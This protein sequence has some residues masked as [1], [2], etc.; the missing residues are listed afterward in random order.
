[1]SRID[2]DAIRQQ[3]VGQLPPDALAGM[4][5]ILPGVGLGATGLP[6]LP[7]RAYEALKIRSEQFNTQLDGEAR[8]F[9]LQVQQDKE[10]VF[11]QF[12][13]EFD[14]NG[15]PIMDGN[16][17]RLFPNQPPPPQQ[18]TAAAT[19]D[20]PTTT[21]TTQP[22]TT[23][24]P[25]TGQTVTTMETVTTVTNQ[26]M[27]VDVNVPLPAQPIPP[28][29]PE[30]RRQ[31]E[32]WEMRTQNQAVERHK[33]EKDALTLQQRIWFQD[34]LNAHVYDI[35]TPEVQQQI[36]AQAQAFDLQQ[37]QLKE[38]QQ[39]E[40]AQIGL[41]TQE[42]RNR[43]T[44]FGENRHRQKEEFQNSLRFTP[45]G[46]EIAQYE[47]AIKDFTA[48]QRAMVAQMMAGVT[49][50]VQL[51]RFL[52]ELQDPDLARALGALNFQV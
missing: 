16:T 31:R 27:T 6:P 30:Q 17:P 37:A 32:A 19:V 42:L 14:G 49:S 52:P 48:R 47:Q 29:S 41:P 50:Q 2:A 22:V 45:E 28:E 9:S 4:D 26:Q 46:Q 36:A 24:D 3:I 18:V 21:I 20:V 44:A 7:I 38:R 15:N 5:N 12:H 43:V 33:M 1:M 13:Y 34:F 25:V 11:Q 35:A 8:E 51:G 10:A 40:F 39:V 23:I